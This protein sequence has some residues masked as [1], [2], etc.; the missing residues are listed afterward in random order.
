MLFEE[1]LRSGAD[2]VRFSIIHLIY[3][4]MF[5]F[6]LIIIV[7]LDFVQIR[8]RIIRNNRPFVPGVMLLEEF[9]RSGT[10]FVR[11]S[12]VFNICYAVLCT[13][14]FKILPMMLSIFSDRS[15]TTVMGFHNCCE[16]LDIPTIL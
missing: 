7:V 1:F 14:I 11:F 15:I 3:F 5:Q 12:S 4:M 2:F 10:D 16:F 13:L 9:L 6:F 8:F